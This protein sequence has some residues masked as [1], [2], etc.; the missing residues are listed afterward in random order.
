[1]KIII[2]NNSTKKTAAE[3]TTAVGGAIETN[4]KGLSGRS[5]TAVVGELVF[6]GKK[7]GKDYYFTVTDFRSGAAIVGQESKQADI[8]TSK[9]VAPT[10]NSGGGTTP[11]TG[12]PGNSGT[13]P[14][15]PVA[16]DSP[17]DVDVD[18]VEVVEK[19]KPKAKPKAK[20]KPVKSKEAVKAK[21]KKNSK[22]G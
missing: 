22:K 11:P 13:S 6:V 14:A 7:P 21:L 3:V 1:M 18:E 19:P 4:F 10:T 5:T 15:P 16:A 17:E 12:T 8:D 2:R 9:T 20:A